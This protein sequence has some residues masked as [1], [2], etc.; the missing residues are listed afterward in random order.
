MSPHRGGA[1]VPVP[2]S[3]TFRPPSAG[4]GLPGAGVVF[5]SASSAPLGAAWARSSPSADSIGATVDA[6]RAGDTR[7]AG[8]RLMVGAGVAGEPRV[9]DHDASPGSM[10]QIA[11]ACQAYDETLFCPNIFLTC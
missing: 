1:A 8:G 11:Q 5:S 10:Q 3:V 2:G 7:S 4:G 6:S 9:P